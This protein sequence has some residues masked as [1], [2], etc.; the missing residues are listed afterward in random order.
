MVRKAIWQSEQFPDYHVYWLRTLS[1]KIFCKLIN[2]W[3]RH[4]K[5]F[6][7][8][9]SIISLHYQTVIDQRL[10][11]FHQLLSWTSVELSKCVNNKMIGSQ[12]DVT[13]WGVAGVQHDIIPRLLRSSFFQNEWIFKLTIK[14]INPAFD[15]FKFTLLFQT[16]LESEARSSLPTCQ[17]SF[18]WTLEM[19]NRQ[20]NSFTRPSDSL[21]NSFNTICNG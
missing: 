4:L 7:F 6:H 10:T 11:V 8:R 18:S 20:N 15:K 1:Q 14:K 13:V 19:F 12:G 3:S 17:L 5:I 9:L 16:V 2:F 21:R